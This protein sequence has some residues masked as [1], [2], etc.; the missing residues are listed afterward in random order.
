[1]IVLRLVAG[2]VDLRSLGEVQVSHF[3]RSAIERE[4]QSPVVRRARLRSWSEVEQ[5]FHPQV[6]ARIVVTR[7]PLLERGVHADGIIVFECILE[8]TLH[9]VP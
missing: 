3:D 1:M 9:A 4:S 8:C 6:E 2:R 5:R 7:F